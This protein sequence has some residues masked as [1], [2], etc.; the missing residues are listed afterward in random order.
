[1]T[2]A[3]P[4]PQPPL[5]GGT[6]PFL[7]D[8]DTRVG[9][10][11]G[12]VIVT[13]LGEIDMA[14][15]PLLWEC[16]AR[17]IPD[18]ERRLVIDLA[19]TTFIDSTGLALFARAHQRLRRGGAELMLRAPN[20]SARLVLHITGLDQVI[21]IEDGSGPDRPCSLVETDGT[22]PPPSAS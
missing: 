4:V 5:A 6:E 22:A 14:S 1:M 16:L 3:E 12:E 18:A 20:S 19:G 11:D 15:G 21:T 10:L 2:C 9:R 13:V 17:T 7:V 8:F